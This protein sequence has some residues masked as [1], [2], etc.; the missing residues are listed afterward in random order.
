MDFEKFLSLIDKSA[1]YFPRLD[2]LSK[3]DPYEGHF[4]HV[5]AMIGN[6]EITLFD[7]LKHQV[8]AHIDK[9]KKRM[10]EV[11][12]KSFEDTED[13]GKKKYEDDKINIDLIALAHREI[14]R[15]V[16]NDRNK[17]FVHS[18]HMQ[19]YESAAMWSL[20]AK[21]SNGIAIVSTYND[22]VQSVLD[23]Q[24]YIVYIGIVN[25][26]D[27]RKD[28]IPVKNML[29]PF[30]YKRKSF[31]HEKE[32]RALIHVR[33]YDEYDRPIDTDQNINGIY[34]NVNLNELIKIIYISPTAEEW[35]VDLIKS[36]LKKYNLNPL[37]FH[38]DL[39]SSAPIY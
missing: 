34:V 21:Y 5:N 37:V 2:K 10:I 8:I 17:I 20:Y 4:T 22:L 27:Y 11:D 9:E 25:Y 39:Q 33:K 18:W 32:L 1:L 15:A 38:S 6:E 12:N 23:N 14:P 7:Q 3:V 26:I 24:D 19:E 36:I 35:I 13:W 29:S 31:E 28:H 16:L 30:L